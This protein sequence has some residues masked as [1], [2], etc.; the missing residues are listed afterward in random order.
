MS[1]PQS[2]ENALPRITDVEWK[3]EALTNTPGV[4]SDKLLYSVILKTDKDDV[5]FTCDTQ[6]LQDLVY[7][8]KDLVRHCENVKSEL[9]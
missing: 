2:D 1:T 4:G 3:L 8:L 5:T 9:T 6:Q 7:K